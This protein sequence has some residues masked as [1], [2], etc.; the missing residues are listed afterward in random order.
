MGF[1][2]TGLAKFVDYVSPPQ[3]MPATIYH[4]LCEITVQPYTHVKIPRLLPILR[5]QR[6]LL[7]T[8]NQSRWL[9]QEGLSSIP[10]STGADSRGSNPAS[11]STH[12]L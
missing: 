3:V 11:Y 7:R 6:G 10:A 9:H 2:D 12:E 4:Q 5:S 1:F 8:G